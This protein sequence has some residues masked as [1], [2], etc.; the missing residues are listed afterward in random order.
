LVVGTATGN[1]VKAIHSVLFVTP[2]ALTLA[3]P[4]ARADVLFDNGPS[5]GW[6]G[7]AHDLTGSIQAEDF[8]LVR[9][10]TIEAIRFY[11]IEQGSTYAGS[12]LWSFRED[13]DE[14]PAPTAIA[15]SLIAADRALTGIL[16]TDYRNSAESLVTVDIDPVTLGPGSY[17]LTLHNGPLSNN[18]PA[19]STRMLMWQSTSATP[20]PGLV[21]LEDIV[22][23]EGTWENA[24]FGERSF[25]LVGVP[26]P[27]S[28]S[29]LLLVGLAV[30]QRRRG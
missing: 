24:F 27:A 9:P 18:E 16:N 25:Q 19:S 11:A 5:T 2:F 20:S 14:A 7:I 21:G 22:P 29:S 6:V 12:I 4:C 13:Q 3:A 15:G 26:E 8:T 30:R 1:N 17:W 28:V 23:F 10:V